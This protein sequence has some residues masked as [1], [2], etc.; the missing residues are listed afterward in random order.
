LSLHIGSSV[1]L[2]D[3]YT[4]TQYSTKN[5]KSGVT[6][7]AEGLDLVT[8]TLEQIS[9]DLSIQ[10]SLF[11]KENEKFGDNVEALTMRNISLNQEIEKLKETEK[12]LRLTQTELETACIELKKSVKGQSTLVDQ[13]QAALNKI[14]IDFERNQRELEEKNKQLADLHKQFKAEVTRYEQVVE[15]LQTAVNEL[16]ENV[17]KSPE[18]QQ[19]FYEKV[20]NFIQDKDVNFLKIFEHFNDTEKELTA[21]KEKYK[22]LIDQYELLVEQEASQLKKI[23]RTSSLLDSH[24]FYAP[25]GA[26]QEVAS[27]SHQPRM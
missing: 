7:L 8:Q 12:K 5:I 21:L 19:A 4:H 6:S 14:R 1:I 27:T 22:G 11:S 15:T 24:G 18:Q 25:P 23:E 20:N 9:E 10:V 17:L 3:H 2:D 13:T 26:K 16:A